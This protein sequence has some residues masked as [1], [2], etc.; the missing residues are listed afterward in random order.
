[1]TFPAQSYIAA[2]YESQLPVYLMV[3]GQI[4]Q[5]FNQHIDEAEKVSRFFY[6]ASFS[7]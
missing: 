5:F 7:T 6:D 4:L 3:E 2:Y 1:V